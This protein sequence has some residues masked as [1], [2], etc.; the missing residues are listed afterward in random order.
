MSSYQRSL[1]LNLRLTLLGALTFAFLLMLPI[2]WTH[3]LFALS[4][5]TIILFHRRAPILQWINAN[6]QPEEPKSTP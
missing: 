2:F 4:V 5:G 1:Y 6:K 3:M